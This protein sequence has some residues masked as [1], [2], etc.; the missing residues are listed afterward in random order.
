MTREDELRTKANEIVEAVLAR[1]VC[2]SETECV[3]VQDVVRAA[4]MEV[5]CEVW[6]KVAEHCQSMHNDGLTLNDVLGCGNE[7]DVITGACND[8][9]RTVEKWARGQQQE[10]G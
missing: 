4:L 7:G 2:L 1:D 8:E 5:E 10:L 3:I 6:G 9:L